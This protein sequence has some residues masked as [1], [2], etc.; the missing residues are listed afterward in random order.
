M[1]PSGG[2]R[3]HW[4]AWRSQALWR[5]TRGQ[6]A[7]WLAQ[8]Q[9]HSDELLLI[10]ASAGWML[11]SPWLQRFRRIQVW[12][13][14]PLAKPLFAWRHGPALR[15]ALT[16]WDYHCGDALKALPRLIEKH[17]Q[18]CIFFD[19]VLGQL[20][21]HAGAGPQA[22]TQIEERLRVIKQQLG[23]REWGSVHDLL[24]GPGLRFRPGQ[25]LPPAR[26]RLLEPKASP[27]SDAW[28]APLGANGQWLD[29]LT[30]AVFAPGTPICDI[31]WPFEPAYWHWLQGGWVSPP[32]R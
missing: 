10:G 24:S 27:E 26:W 7:D 15:A 4:R 16:H 32:R 31:A 21:F 1:S 13:L 5:D 28:L 9:P 25:V 17:P 12:D 22:A 18:A 19:N 23:G 11:P 29:H 30:G 6:I 3:W 8:V 2:L 20:R 14:D